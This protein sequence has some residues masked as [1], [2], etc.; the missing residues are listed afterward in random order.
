MERRASAAGEGRNVAMGATGN[1]ASFLVPVEVTRLNETAGGQGEGTPR[2]ENQ[3]GTPTEAVERNQNQGDLL[4]NLGPLVPVDFHGVAGR[5]G[6]E[7]P[8]LRRVEVASQGVGEHGRGSLVSPVM[9]G[10]TLTFP[11]GAPT[12][13]GPT[14]YPAHLGHPG[15]GRNDAPPQGWMEQGFFPMQTPMRQPALMEAGNPFWSPEARSFLGGP[16][17]GRSSGIAVE[18][19]PNRA[20]DMDPNQSE[21]RGDGVRVGL[22]DAVQEGLSRMVTGVGEHLFPGRDPLGW[23]RGQ[24]Q[25]Q[26]VQTGSPEVEMDPIELFRI[27]CLREAEQKF[28]Q[29]IEQM[30]RRQGVEKPDGSSGSF[31]TVDEQR[32]P[33]V[34][35]QALEQPPGLMGFRGPQRAGNPRVEGQG[36]HSGTQA[37]GGNYGSGTGEVAT[38][39]LRSV[40]L[41]PLPSE[42]SS[43]QFG[44]WLAMIEPLLA[45][46]SYSSG[47]WWSKIMDTVRKAYEAWLVEDPLGRLRLKVEIPQEALAWPRTEKRALAMLLQALP[48]KLRAEM[49]AA[50]KLTTPQLM[51]RLYCLFQPGG[52]AERSSLLQLLTESKGMN[53]P[54]EMA[55]TMRQWLRWLERS[56]ELGLVLPDPMVL[57]GVLGKMSDSMS[58]V[59]TQV[60]FRL[61]STRQKLMMDGRPSLSD[62]KVF[63]EYLLAEAEDLSLN[64]TVSLG[65]GSGNVSGKP[66]VKMLSTPESTREPLGDGRD[67]G[68]V[69][70]NSSQVTSKNACRYWLTEEGCKRGDKCKFVHT[71]L[72]PKDG[73]CF[74]CSGVGHG[75]RECP[76]QQKKKLAKT[77]AERTP[78]KPGLENAKGSGKD[79][80]IPPSGNESLEGSEFAGSQSENPNG[81]GKGSSKGSG[82]G[83]SKGNANTPQDGFQ[84]LMQEATSLMKSLRPSIKAVRPTDQMCKVVSDN[85]PTGLLDGGATNALR[86]GTSE[87][88]A[89]SLVVTVELA[90]GTAELHQN[91]QTGTLL[92]KIPVEPIVPLRG[93]VELGY[94]IKWDSKGCEIYHPEHGKLT[95]W[96]RN[97]CPVVREEH[98]LQLIDDME[99]KQR[100]RLLG[101]K[102]AR[103]DVSGEVREW[104]NKE[105][106]SIPEDVLSYMGGQ[107]EELPPGDQL[108]WNRRCRRRFLNAKAIVIHLFSGKCSKFWRDGWPAGVECVTVDVAEDSRQNLHD[109]GVWSFLNYLV[110]TKNVIAIVGGPPCRTVSR[111]RNLRPGPKPLRGRTD[112]R[113]GL[114]ELT[115][116]EKTMTDSDSALMLKQL[117]L[118]KMAQSHN[119]NPLPVGFLMESP[120]DPSTYANEPEAP[121]FW[122][123]EEVEDFARDEKMKLISLDQGSLGH[124]QRKPTSCLTNLPG[125]E[126]LDGLR[127]DENYGQKLQTDLGK[128]FEQT[129]S[130]STWAPGLKEV[131][132][133]GIL[134]MGVLRGVVDANCKKVLNLTQWKQHILQGHRPYRRDCR[135]C[136]LDMASGPPHRRRL[137]AGTSAWSLGVDVVLFGET[138]DDITGKDVKYAVVGTALVPH[139]REETQP[140]M[141]SEPVEDVEIPNWGEGL[142]EIEYPLGEENPEAPI[143]EGENPGE[144]DPPRLVGSGENFEENK[145]EKAVLDEVEN[146][147]QPLSL[148]HVTMVEPIASRSTQ[149]VL[150][151]L[152]LIV[153]RM[154]SLGINVNRLHGDRA[155]ELLSAKTESWCN[156]HGL[157]RTL[158]GGTTPQTMEGLSQKSNSLKEG[159]DCFCEK[160]M[161]VFQI[162]QRLCDMPPKKD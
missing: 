147:S 19:N 53:T 100:E 84:E 122:C 134:Q 56:E 115:E 6:N 151:A 13:Y 9:G 106:P 10:P 110:R 64:T 26:P 22:G 74:N 41:P 46:I 98:A 128:R 12:V 51:F 33:D 3:T 88:L 125:L 36:L 79:K 96:L 52:Q 42:A 135:A 154:K 55:S 2:L 93:I 144:S 11:Q 97:G 27:R 47:E 68:L 133:Q 155:K 66:S 39:T 7:N 20:L 162:G 112:L 109:T 29:G 117:G 40:D 54:Q 119:E 86:M 152:T 25:G 153:I 104:W 76:H 80:T 67:K 4:R 123:W 60:A 159:L 108:P 87:E 107:N 1:D 85:C 146:C 89:Q 70:S 126:G 81:Q 95:C 120:Q 118:Y 73:R 121:S 157:I 65:S 99:R 142:D 132:K 143:R 94:K 105:F 58:K 124:P 38:E 35:N 92:T 129:A 48:E 24:N 59:G 78:R 17:E 30:Q 150:H 91:P 21:P 63:A 23:F 114:P 77:Q 113:Y 138:K 116:A 101:P 45:D 69:P 43:I 72:E 139:F 103:G 158:G 136:V 16:L 83:Q 149:D 127:A 62:V 18:G 57:A 49:V 50:R 61:S 31:K 131:V 37:F 5:M 82:K 140:P 14:G 34:G 71:V 102:I 130:W 15:F 111:L 32:L 156:R 44:D 75:K 28:A 90:S 160:R 148:K 141:K 8:G 137:Y 161:G 145:R